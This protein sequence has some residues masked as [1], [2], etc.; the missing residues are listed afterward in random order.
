MIMDDCGLDNNGIAGWCPGYILK[1]ELIKSGDRSNM[2]YKV[3]RGVEG[4][5]FS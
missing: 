2:R 1:A 3:K 4:F 5:G